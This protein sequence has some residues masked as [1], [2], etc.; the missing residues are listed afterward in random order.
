[1][2][3]NDIHFPDSRIDVNKTAYIN[4]CGHS[5]VDDWPDDSH[6]GCGKAGSTR[7]ITSRDNDT[8]KNGTLFDYYAATSGSGGDALSTINTNAPDTFCP[9]GW[10]M[11]YSG[12]GGDY[13]DKS[14][15]WSFLFNA[16]HIENNSAGGI[17]LN[18]YP[19]HV[20][21]SGLYMFNL[22]Y[23]FAQGGS[24]I[25]WTDTVYALSASYRMDFTM[26]NARPN[27]THD[28]RLGYTIRCV[29]FLSSPHRRHGG[30]DEYRTI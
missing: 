5:Y 6:N 10:Q 8:Q 21:L 25:Y 20:A 9:L 11:P 12:S 14:K 28:K 19:L 7:L 27:S 1:M 30:R 18:T 24:G 2:E 29:R 15:S 17:K 23:A 16:Y 3:G 13:Y 22:G 4:G 26:G